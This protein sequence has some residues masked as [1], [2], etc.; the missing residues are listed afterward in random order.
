MKRT[1]IVQ[2][3]SVITDKFKIKI[4]KYHQHFHNPESAQAEVCHVLYAKK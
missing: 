1:I 4:I 2:V 3:G